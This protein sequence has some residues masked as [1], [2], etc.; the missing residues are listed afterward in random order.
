M[1]THL[2]T[3]AVVSYQGEQKAGTK[4]L[5]VSPG[6]TVYGLKKCLAALVDHYDGDLNLSGKYIHTRYH[7]DLRSG[8]DNVLLS[9]DNY[10]LDQYEIRNG[11]TIEMRLPPPD[12]VADW[13]YE[14]TAFAS[15][16]GIVFVKPLTGRTITIDTLDISMARVADLM[17][18][19]KDKEGVPPLEQKIE[20]GGRQMEAQDL[21]S[22]YGVRDKST[23]GLALQQSKV[24]GLRQPI[25]PGATSSLWGGAGWFSRGLR[26]T[27]IET[28]KFVFHQKDSGSYKGTLTEIE[29]AVDALIGGLVAVTGDLLGLAGLAKAISI[30]T[31]KSRQ[32]TAKVMFKHDKDLK[33][34][35]GFLSRGRR[36]NAKLKGPFL[37]GNRS[38]SE[39]SCDYYYIQADPDSPKAIAALDKLQKY[40]DIKNYYEEHF[41][42]KP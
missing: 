25:A 15:K 22:K 42:V 39:V 3:V 9:D 37:S 16:K 36:I 40:D 17:M 23:V 7:C 19:V 26:Q 2:I 27:T 20:F 13:P 1:T 18:A 24:V 35:F 33:A 10:R 6:L 5:Q 29:V 8:E 31:G 28:A 38:V 21:L 30:S 12:A 41:G 34:K 4:E 11:S 32:E 14:R